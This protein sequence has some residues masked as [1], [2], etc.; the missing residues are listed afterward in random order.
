MYN[1]VPKRP[2]GS[3][4]SH[5]APSE[6]TIINRGTIP[7]IVSEEDFALVQQLLDSRKTVYP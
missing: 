3:R 1:R 5:A 4:N 2:N 7:A 6:E